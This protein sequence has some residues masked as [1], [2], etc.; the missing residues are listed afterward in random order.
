MA[1]LLL[2]RHGRAIRRKGVAAKLLQ[3]PF[4]NRHTQSSLAAASAAGNCVGIVD[5]GVL[6]VH[7]EGSVLRKTKGTVNGR[8]KGRREREDVH[9]RLTL[10]DIMK[11]VLPSIETCKGVRQGRDVKK[12][13]RSCSQHVTSRVG[14][15][16]WR[17]A[18]ECAA[19]QLVTVLLLHSS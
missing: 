4:L 6:V 11:V 17:A 9:D 18:S 8:V 10:V 15:G 1:N 3:R 12:G 16:A 14:F 5:A 13:A 2:A 7:I 19:L